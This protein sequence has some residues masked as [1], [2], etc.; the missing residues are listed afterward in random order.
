MVVMRQKKLAV[1]YGLVIL[2][3]TSLAGCDSFITPTRTASKMLS[4]SMRQSSAADHSTAASDDVAV[5]D[6]VQQALLPPLIPEGDSDN[7][8]RFDVDADNL[9]APE[10]FASLVD[11]TSIN[12]VVAPDV[13]GRITLH[14]KDVTLPEV[15]DIV[16]QV[17][18]YHYSSI[19]GGYHI[20]PN[21][22][23]TR[24]FQVDYLTLKRSGLSTTKVSSGQITDSDNN[25]D[26]NSDSSDGNDSSTSD[27]SSSSNSDN[28]S[29]S[30]VETSSRSDF[31]SDFQATLEALVGTDGGRQV[32]VQPQAG[33][34]LVK[35]MP[36]ELET[37]AD[38]LRQ[39]QGSMQRQVILEAKI[40]E[41]QLNDGYQTGINWGALMRDGT[42][43]AKFGQ[44]GG[45]TVFTD[46]TSPISG[47]LGNL[48]PTNP[49]TMNGLVTS[50][51]G[52][53]FSAAIEVDNFQAFIEAVK[54]QGDVQVLSSP[55]VSTLNNQKA[56]IKVGSDE[57]FV[58]DISSDTVT[59]TTTTTTPDITL[60][61]FFSGI[62][63]DVTPQI[64][65]NG[66][67]TLHIHPIVSDVTDQTKVITVSGQDQSLPLA[68][69]TVR[70]SD[71]IVRAHSG[72]VIVI[73]GLMKN[74]GS[75]ETAAVPGLGSIPGVGALFKHR[76]NK[77]R[78]SELI[79]LLKPQV[80]LSNQDWY[81]DMEQ[82]RSRIDALR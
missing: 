23:Q 59:G 44:I 45:G 80:I 3:V 37:V 75:N 2:L 16:K 30:R 17:Y 25:D 68:Y 74:V 5:P 32:I 19:A 43:M 63:L 8:L 39:T 64:S 41:V 15:L 60:T 28:A 36:D 35:A 77:V 29:S 78:K 9:P 34:V 55:R 66:D 67:V 49:L 47:N 12:M 70:E 26:N 58:T 71:T 22:L 24:I 14:L 76:Q 61:P 10:F 4:D 56:I 62:A 18:G 73:G 11:A 7:Q 82:S 79:I 21:K 53:V 81:D 65:A 51:F 20:L 50:A 33:I 27:G 31:W 57:F 1:I 54:S 52:G 46:G 40:I 69:S 72:Q 42:D 13:Q 48:D 6:T 38:Y